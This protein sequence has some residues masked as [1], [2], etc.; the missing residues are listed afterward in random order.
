MPSECDL[1]P[2]ILLVGESDFLDFGVGSPRGPV[3]QRAVWV[4]VTLHFSTQ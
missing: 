1:P 4:K 3:T 2:L